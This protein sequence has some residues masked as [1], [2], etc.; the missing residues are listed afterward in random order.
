[1]TRRR[2]KRT[3]MTS[4]GDLISQR[5]GFDS[6]AGHDLPAEGPLAAILGRGSC[7]RFAER[8]VDDGLL[9]V[10]LAC[11]QS[12]PA[13]SDMQQYSIVVVR[14]D[15]SRRAL[16]E[17]CPTQPWVGQAPV[18][19]VFCAD[20][21]RGRRIAEMRGYAHANDNLDTFMNAVV[22][23]ALAMQTL[24]LA[25]E[26][27]GLG[28]CPISLIRDRIAEVSALLALPAGVFPVAGLCLGWPARQ[29][30]VSM[31]LAPAVVVHRDRYD[32]T[33][34]EA[35]IAAY[36]ARRH[37]RRPITAD[38][39]RHTDRYGVLDTCP[40]SE[41]VARQLSVPERADFRAFL[42]GHGLGLE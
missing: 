24:V 33:R 36:D 5:F 12:A 2:T 26:A 6:G 41:N 17:W 22:D 28:C 30:Q 25:A 10:L 29:P 9:D 23:A 4:L 19:A 40:W 16:A 7:R 35:E 38:N 11:A 42:E 1:M 32:E 13:K 34:L 18:F 27:A 20:V 3:P 39:Q 8:P 15:A 14:E 31:R 37:A 21:A